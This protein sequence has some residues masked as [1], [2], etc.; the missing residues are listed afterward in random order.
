MAENEGLTTILTDQAVVVHTYRYGNYVLT[1][2][3][4]VGP[5]AWAEGSPEGTDMNSI[6]STVRSQDDPRSQHNQVVEEIQTG[7]RNLQQ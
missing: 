3:V 5:A 2:I 4:R 6:D 1:D 7:N